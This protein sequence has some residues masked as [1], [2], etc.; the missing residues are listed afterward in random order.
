MNVKSKI[1]KTV[2][3]LIVFCV[4]IVAQPSYAD[5]DH[6][7]SLWNDILGTHVNSKGRVDYK[8]IISS[9]KSFDQYIQI[10]GS[11]SRVEYNAWTRDQQLSY[12]INAYN[13]FAIKVILDNY[14]IK[15][16][17]GVKAKFYPSNSIQQIPRVWDDVKNS[18]AGE[19][20][21]LN[22]IEHEIIRKKFKEPRI[23]FSID[24]ASIGCPYIWDHAFDASK[25]EEHLSAAAR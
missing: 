6:S 2:N 15:Q 7:H 16:G 11:V 3:S 10:V 24:C 13:A 1:F 21:A 22:Q 12:W 20:V 18:A 17:K 19:H 25:L 8:A 14:P 5:F 4:I 23:H 9:R